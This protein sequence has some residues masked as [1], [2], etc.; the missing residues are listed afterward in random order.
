M[1]HLPGAFF[2]HFPEKILMQP[3]LA[4]SSSTGSARAILASPASTDP[5]QQP[6]I[7]LTILNRGSDIMTVLSGLVDTTQSAQ[8]LCDLA[9]INSPHFP[10]YRPDGAGA[11][12]IFHTESGNFVLGSVRANPAL[13]SVPAPSGQPYPA[14]MNTCLGGYLPDPQTSLR[15]A[16]LSAARPKVLRESLVLETPD[17]R[18]VQGQLSQLLDVIEADAGWEPR[19]CI[20]TDRWQDGE[21]NEKTMCFLTA[22]KHLQ[23]TE[24]DR[25]ALEQAFKSNAMLPSTSGREPM[26][27]GFA[28]LDSVTANALDTYA[29]DEVTKATRAWEAHGDTVTVVFNDLATAALKKNR[30]FECDS[31]A[32]LTLLGQ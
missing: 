27:F 19:I 15:A 5:P 17:A 25:N 1:R 31:P 22:V 32:R 29:A 8:S 6:V 18:R 24:A 3:S 11:I 20:H 26:A 13:Q 30:A 12:L 2:C 4:D 10:A 21:G 14:Q 16:I 7:S 23:C 9:G 28:P